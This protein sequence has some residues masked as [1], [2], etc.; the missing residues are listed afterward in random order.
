MEFWVQDPFMT[1]TQF[2]NGYTN[3]AGGTMYINLGNVSEDVLKDGR[4]FYENGLPTPTQ[5][6]LAVD[7]STV[8]GKAPLNPIQITQAFSNDANDRPYQDVG[9]DGLNDNEE[10]KRHSDYLSK[11]GNVVGT[12]SAAYQQAA[13][14]PSTDNFVNYR[15][16]TYDASNAGILRRYRDY[17]LNQGNS[18]VSTGNS[19][20]IEASTLYPDNEDLNRDNTLNESEEYFEYKIDFKPEMAVGQ[21]NISDIR[22]VSIK[23]ENGTTGTEKWYQFRVPIAGYNRK[24][25]NIPDFKSIRFMRMYLTGWQDS[26][27]LRFA[28]LDLVRNNWRQF[29]FDLTRNGTYKQIV[30][31]GFTTLNTLAVNI[32]ENDRRTPIPYRIPPGIERVQ[33]IANGGVNILQ[34]E[35]SLSLQ[36]R[37][38]NS[39]DARGVF[40]TF[41][42]DLRQY[43]KLDMFIHAEELPQADRAYTPLTDTS[44]YATVRIGQDYISNYYEVRIPLTITRPAG[45][46]IKPEEIWPDSNNLNLVLGDL[47]SLKNRRNNQPGASPTS[48]YSEQIG[49]RIYAVYGNP[50][51]G[52]VKGIFVG[53][54]NPYRLDGPS[55]STEMWINEL[56]L[57]MLD[58]QTGYAAVGR[59]DIQLADLGTMSIAANHTSVGFGTIEQRVNE[60][61]RADKTQVDASLQIDAGKLLPKAVGVTIPLYASISSNTSSPEYDPY[62]M[63]VKLSDKIKNS[64]NKDSIKSVARD[65]QV[66]KTLNISN[67]RV[68]PRKGS[69]NHIY[70]ISNFDVTYNFLE[71]SMSSPIVTKDLIKRHRVMLGYNYVSQPVYWEPFK[72]LVKS[73]SP[74]LTF[75]KDFNINPVPSNIAFRFDVN[76][77]FGRYV[78]RIV[79]S[80]DN[81]VETVDSTYD[82]YF[83]FD[84]FYSFRWDLTRS[85]NIDYTATNKSRV[86]EPA[87]ELNTRAKKD[88]MWQNFYKGGRNVN[89]DQNII[90]TY[91]IPTSKFPFLDWTNMRASY[92]AHYRWTASS[93]LAQYL[94]QGNIL[95]NGSDRV[96]N[97]ELDF[98]RLYNK[99]RWL[100]ALE[101]EPRK[102]KLDSAGRK[103]LKL[104]KQIAKIQKDSIERELNKLPPK[105]R[106]L[107]RRQAKLD[108]RNERKSRNIE[109][110][111]LPR[112]VGKLATMLKR[113]SINYGEIYY[114]RLP[115][116]TDSTRFFGQN[117]RTSA[118]GFGYILGQT[119]DTNTLNKFA[120]KNLVTHDPNFNQLFAQ[121]FDQKFSLQAQLEPFKEFMIDVNLDKTFSKNYTELFKDTI[122][123]SSLSHLSPYVTGSFSVSYISFQTLFNKFNP[124][125]N[126]ATFKR[127]Q[128][129]RQ[130]LSLRAAANNP[131]WKTGGS[132]IGAD[133]YAQ[134]YNRYAQE[135][136]IPAFI[137][138]Y[139]KKDPNSVALI[140]NSNANVKSNPFAGIKPLPNWR[141][142]FTGLSKIEALQKTFSA[143]TITHSYQ[144]RMS[145]NS[146]TSAL[147]FQDPFRVGYPSFIDTTSGN[148]I[149]Y[150]LVPNLTIQESFEPLIGIDVTTTGQ[151]NARVEYKKS[152]QLSLSLIDYQLSEINSTEYAISASW[153]K[154]G[155]KLPFT[156]PKFLNKDGGKDLAND[157][158]FRFD[159]SVRDDATSNSRL[160]QNSS[161]S[162]AGQ[163]VIHINPTID[164][165]FNNRINLKFYFDQLRSFPY[166]STAAPTINTRAGLQI[167]ISLAQ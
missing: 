36:G 160:D 126:S 146:F 44:L 90:A 130:I 137:A 25:G 118:P 124:N 29:A 136:L 11:L 14:D 166:I 40:K 129:F 21:N 143:I 102:V 63:D 107:A 45:P 47:I 50:N 35:Q 75:I 79:N 84:R 20:I 125:E 127:F 109:I 162:T 153:R 92:T 85:I 30:P 56:R 66:T 27:T 76:R 131:Y 139:T 16:S 1:T 104:Q 64:A 57:S 116:Y 52:E 132:Q 32:E 81:K 72:K 120:A 19:N 94:N 97:G 106:E 69:K 114:S 62:D 148:F 138:A 86:D 67:M 105:E 158:T 151:L 61:S 55:L 141:L 119:P 58:E 53:I 98:S 3:P 95:E 74:W 26:V 121:G 113:A 2:P 5:P 73:K 123:N 71:Q 96:V 54:D 140:S 163:K 89:F 164:Y 41:N 91:T 145:M 112:V 70:S 110:V 83:N 37:F 39:G 18:P 80:F 108:K 161:F 4:R 147:L 157:I 87:G 134:G 15:N 24:V 49:K 60:R 34:N 23:Y 111:G 152:R 6:N 93:L 142:N 17:N 77:Q 7:S 103:M 43:K 122:G 149:P 167:R 65:Q 42:N 10:R 82:K 135:V 101:N 155:L 100:A 31:N 33:Q 154:R 115:G 165:V 133:G 59:V 38:I 68:A 150:F 128:D 156:L 88:S 8:W 117:F 46:N 28:R 51:L 78:P 22:Y 99:S 9:F 13:K 12:G 48:Y 159:F 144:G